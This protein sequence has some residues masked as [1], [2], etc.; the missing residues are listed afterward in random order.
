MAEAAPGTRQ[1]SAHAHAA[2]LD[3]LNLLD[4]FSLSTAAL[5]R[6]S[7]SIGKQRARVI[8]PCQSPPRGHPAIASRGGACPKAIVAE[9]ASPCLDPES[10]RLVRRSPDWG[11]HAHEPIQDPARGGQQHHADHHVR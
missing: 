8:G 3:H 1:A 11:R 2:R 10:G 5:F 6:R 4:A 9:R 7:P